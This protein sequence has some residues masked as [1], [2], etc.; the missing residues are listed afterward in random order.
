MSNEDKLDKVV[1]HVKSQNIAAGEN[2][3]F[4]SKR[5]LQKV[6]ETKINTTMIGAISAMEQKFG[7]L[8]GQGKPTSQLTDSERDMMD[9]KDE[10]RT[11]ILNNGNNQKRAAVAEINQYEVEWKRH[12]MEMHV[13]ER[14]HPEEDENGYRP[15]TQRTFTQ[16][17]GTDNNE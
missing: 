11:E 4:Q 16:E 7:F 13:Q 9:L 2:Y 10:L 12:H 5:R 6:V 8:W 17:Q 1:R 15:P 14:E 3:K